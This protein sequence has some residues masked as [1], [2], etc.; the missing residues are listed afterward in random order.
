VKALN[1]VD[2]RLLDGRKLDGR[3]ISIPICGHDADAKRVVTALI[4]EL[5]FDVVDAG[6]IDSSRLLEPLTL[7]MIRLSM[8]KS[9]GN[10]IGFRVLRE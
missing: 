5:G 9:L 8:K 2:A 4:A 6:E 3:E 1:I 7:L 10:E